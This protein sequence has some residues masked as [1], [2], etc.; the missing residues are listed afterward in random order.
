MRKPTILVADDDRHV[1][2][3]LRVRLSAWGYRV[4]E[5]EDGLGVL[6]Q[7][8]RGWVDAV[9]LDHEMP[10]GNG[11]AV[12]RVIR[13]ESDVPI[14]FLSG[15]DREEFRQIVMQLPDVY[16]L[17]KP[18]DEKRLSELLASIVQERCRSCASRAEPETG[19]RAATVESQCLRS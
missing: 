6:G 11:R 16:Y 13:N 12:A 9:I 14:I 7:C 15:H 17:P 18:L 8:P 4:V 2:A 5:S 19:E 3:A 1:R 10:C